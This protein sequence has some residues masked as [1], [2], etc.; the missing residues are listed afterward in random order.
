MAKLEQAQSSQATEQVQEIQFLR[1]Q[2]AQLRL[3]NEGLKT[4]L[5]THVYGNAWQ[6]NENLSLPPV[7]PSSHHQTASHASSASR[8]METMANDNSMQDT[9]GAPNILPMNQLAITSSMLPGAMHAFGAMPSSGMQSV[10]YSMTHPTGS[11]SSLKE[12]QGNTEFVPAV[13]AE[14]SSFQTMTI[15]LTIST[16]STSHVTAQQASSAQF[17]PGRTAVEPPK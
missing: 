6:Y 12:M 15:P 1:T 16:M 7:V 14:A 10:Q 13:T 9:F 3:E 8:I 2:N 11:R 4:T 17:I 5:K